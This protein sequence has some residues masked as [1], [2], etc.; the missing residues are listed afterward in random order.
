MLQKSLCI[1]VRILIARQSHSRQHISSQS[2][3]RAHYIPHPLKKV[4]V[5]GGQNARHSCAITDPSGG[6][7]QS[8]SQAKHAS[9]TCGEDNFTRW[10]TH[11]FQHSKNGHRQIGELAAP[12]GNA[13]LSQKSTTSTALQKSLNNRTWQLSSKVAMPHKIQKA[14]KDFND[15]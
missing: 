8:Q 6:P 7:I 12:N 5:T 13:S 15:K 11:F 1:F 3:L 4:Q 2:R 10:K 14:K 9:R